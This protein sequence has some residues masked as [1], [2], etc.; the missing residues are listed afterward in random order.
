[1]SI[2]MDDAEKEI[3][4]VLSKHNLELYPVYD[5]GLTIMLRA[6]D[7]DLDGSINTHQREFILP[8]LS[9]PYQD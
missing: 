2:A 1:M 3:K 4:S 5:E 7:K 9:K 8:K 6:V